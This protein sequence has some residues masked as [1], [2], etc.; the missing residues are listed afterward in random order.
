ML[1][2][3][4]P[5]LFAATAL[6]SPVHQHSRLYKR[7]CAAG[8]DTPAEF[9]AYTGYS[10]PA[11]NAVTPPG[12]T[13]TFTNLQASSSADGYG[14]YT[15]LDSY[16]VASCAAQ[17]TS[18]AN[19]Q[20]FNIYFER[21]PAAAPSNCTSSA[22]IKCVFWSGAVSAS[23]A[24]NTGSTQN[25]FQIV[26]A[27]SNGYVASAISPSAGYSMP[28]L[29][30]NNAIQAPLDCNG[31]DTYL[32]FQTFNTS[33]DASRCAA[34][35]SAQAAY[36][37][38]HPPSDGSKPKTCQFFNTYVESK[39]GVAQDQK[40]VLY[41]QTWGKSVATNTGYA[42]GQDVYSVGMSYAYSNATN[43]GVCVKA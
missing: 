41:S 31:K 12:Y 23:N 40:C 19:C 15:T 21:A 39:N 38:A 36:A 3:T 18:R 43:A 20:A 34:A 17:C 29:L 42:Y 35:C 28:V 22:T 30:N 5:L 27:G 8:P 33:F 10:D 1:F 11:L 4:L 9:L 7:A 14:G 24:Q 6:A 37:L 16:D 25:N 32:G 26:I 2:P 13:N